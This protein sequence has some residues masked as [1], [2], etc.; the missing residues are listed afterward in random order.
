M[1]SAIERL[2]TLVIAQ[3]AAGEVIENPAAV[4]KELL[5]NSL[6][7]QANQIDVHIKEAGFVM[8]QVRDNGSGIAKDDLPLSLENFAT[9]KLKNFDD[10]LNMFS[11]GFRGEALASIRSVSQVF[12]ESKQKDAAMAYQISGEHDVISTVKPSALPWGTRV[13]VNHLFAHLPVRQKF[14][15]NISK[16]K[17]K[18]LDV[19]FTYAIGFPACT[20]S[21]QSE[22]KNFHF[23]A[24]SDLR[25]RI[26]QIYP[27]HNIQNF[28]TVY[29][30]EQ[31][32]ELKGYISDFS[33]HKNS[34]EHIF[35][36]V[37]ERPVQY[38][39]LTKILLSVYGEMLAKGNFPLVVLYYNL[40]KSQVD[41]NVHPGK[42]ELRFVDE[43]FLKNFLYNSL[44]KSLVS[45]NPIDRR[46][47]YSRQK[48]LPQQEPPSHMLAEN[49]LPY[50]N[51]EGDILQQESSQDELVSPFA[52]STIG[53]VTKEDLFH[54]QYYGRL[55]NTFAVFACENSLLLMDQH[56]AVERIHYE[57]LLK[58]I[59]AQQDVGH[60]L[61]T[62]LAISLTHGQ[63]HMT[64]TLQ[65][66]LQTLGFQ[67]EN[68]GPAGFSLVSVPYYVGQSLEIESFFKALDLLQ[69]LGEADLDASVL[70]KDL[71]ASLACRAA[72]KKGDEVS[73][74]DLE[75]ILKQ[76]LHCQEPFRCPHGRPTVIKIAREEIFLWFNR[77]GSRAR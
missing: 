56:T 65:Q 26:C 76:L 59:S 31:D 21:F 71:A 22:K 43:N 42:K 15:K 13:Q 8:L 33:I 5:E 35:F 32:H 19:F 36:F 49:F 37:N 10:L 39:P 29:E 27:Q 4:L 64:E 7:A 17:K 3:I 16:T 55:F 72:I 44:K 40:P 48:N 69:E 30:K 46:N 58:K 53:S 2:D 66:P 60:H 18:I 11:F 50:Y 62:P 38:S 52:N 51:P 9:S 23:E 57:Q 74:H 45:E 75:E 73:R 6:D 54:C 12:I 20:F 70:F 14:Q 68:Y 63:A 41:V 1:T 34:K 25:K 28:L 24:E 67:I 47:I 77:M 61:L